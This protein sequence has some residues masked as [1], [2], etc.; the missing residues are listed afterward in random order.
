MMVGIDGGRGHSWLVLF[1]FGDRPTWSCRNLSAKITAPTVTG[2]QI[3]SCQPKWRPQPGIDPPAPQGSAPAPATSSPR[4]R[5]ARRAQGQGNQAHILLHLSASAA[6]APRTASLP[7][8]RGH[9]PERA[10]ESNP[11]CPFSVHPDFR[12]QSSMEFGRPSRPRHRR[13]RTGTATPHRRSASTTPPLRS[14]SAGA[15]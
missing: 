12:P 5:T 11:G 14:R 10:A 9:K 3:A 7:P 6:G 13:R 15:E 8:H 2:A 4:R 1:K